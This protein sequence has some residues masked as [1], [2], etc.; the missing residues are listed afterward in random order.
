MT[1]L[2]SMLKSIQETR[3]A[4]QEESGVLARTE[5]EPQSLR[6]EHSLVCGAQHGQ[7]CSDGQCH[8]SAL[9]RAGLGRGQDQGGCSLVWPHPMGS[10]EEA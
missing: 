10:E 3:V 7:A 1:N 4:T 9:P 6:E 8:G 5:G 2:D